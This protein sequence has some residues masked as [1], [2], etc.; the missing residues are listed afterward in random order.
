[1]DNDERVKKLRDT[2]PPPKE[3]DEEAT[4]RVAARVAAE[5][6]AECNHDAVVA[7]ELRYFSHQKRGLTR[8]HATTLLNYKHHFE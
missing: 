5:K 6:E 1:M 3:S 2:F 7:T 8:R 4:K